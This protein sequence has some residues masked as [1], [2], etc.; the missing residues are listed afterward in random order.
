MMFLNHTAK[1]NSKYWEVLEILLHFQLCSVNII[2]GGQGGMIFTK[3]KTLLEGKKDIG[4][5]FR[6]RTVQL[7][8]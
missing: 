6:L 8:V 5:L 7:T 2:T 1:Y 3:E 4:K